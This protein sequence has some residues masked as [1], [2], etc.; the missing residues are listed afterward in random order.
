MRD[1]NEKDPITVP[2]QPNQPAPLKKS[3]PLI[4][5]LGAVV[6]FIG[7]ANV[8]GLISGKNKTAPRVHCR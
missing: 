8:A 7:I 2:D 3:M 6:L 4:I 1:P 5:G